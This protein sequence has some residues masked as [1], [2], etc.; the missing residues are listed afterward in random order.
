MDFFGAQE[1]ARRQTRWLVVFFLLSVIG[2]ITAVY[3]AVMM[4]FTGSGQRQA[5]T[6]WDPN[7]FLTI[8]AVTTLFIAG[9]S[10]YKISALAAGGG[11]VVAE[12]LG[13]RRVLRSTEDV[14]ERRLLNVIDEMAIASG[15]PVPKVYILDNE[16]G[17]NA[18]AAGFSP[19]Q[20]VVAV[21][22]GCLEQ[23]SRDELQGVIAHE[24]SHILNGDMRLNLRLIGVL[25]GILLLALLGRIVLDN[26]RV[27][28]RSKNGGGIVFFGLALLV[29]GYIGVFFGNLIKAAASRQ[30][31]FLADASAVQFTRN[32]GGIAGALKKIGGFETSAVHHPRAQEASHMF[33]GEGISTMFNWFAT[34]PPIE[35][36]IRRIDRSFVFEKQQQSS[37]TSHAGIVSGFAASGTTTLRPEQ[38]TAS[39]GT[40]AADHVAYARQII[41]SLP[42]SIRNDIGQPIHSRSIIYALLVV[43][44]AQPL[45]VLQRALIN[46]SAEM[47]GK[48]AA[49]VPELKSA[50]RAAWLPILEMVI[51]ALDE[52]DG[53]AVTT[54]LANTKRLIEADGRVTLFEYLVD[55]LLRASISGKPG[56]KGTIHRYSSRN[57]QEDCQTILS[58]LA[59]LGHR[60][61]TIAQTA[62]TASMHHIKRASELPLIARSSL[63]LPRFEQAL[64][65]L[66]TLDFRTR[67][68]IIEACT[69]AIAHD[70]QI[71]ILEA[72]LLRIIGAK[73]DCPIPPLLATA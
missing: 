10:L 14:L 27:S 50:G 69:T 61:L 45:Q 65:R 2:V 31:E 18:F 70:N 8:S 46:E 19:Q 30:R 66:A 24:F 42:P 22:R 56:D 43:D 71:T 59:H 62:F 36:R 33:F 57:M 20:A 5:E 47:I 9:G 54:L 13:G 68:R 67:A 37:A 41:E 25:H 40:I 49:H 34:H 51:P 16:S 39:V 35:E 17:I 58:L 28:S 11:E 23:L 44:E 73:L 72:E 29:I 64:T 53:P 7:L 4:I 48:S 32:P 26:S 60:E 38:V 63:S 52:N 12:S 3:L 15:V 55:S 21:T 6:L 1:Q